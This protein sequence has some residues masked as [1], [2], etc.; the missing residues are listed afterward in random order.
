MLQ[1]GDHRTVITSKLA[2]YRDTNKLRCK[3][4]RGALARPRT[5]TWAR[6]TLRA[7]GQVAVNNKGPYIVATLFSTSIHSSG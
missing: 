2:N 1:E 3:E 6:A 7:T 5:R 4:L